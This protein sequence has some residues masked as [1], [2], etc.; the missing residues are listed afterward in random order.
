MNAGGLPC[1]LA[2]RA[3]PACQHAVG[4]APSPHSPPRSRALTTTPSSAL[5]AV[6]TSA[7]ARI[8]RNHHHSPAAYHRAFA[9]AHHR[10]LALTITAPSAA[11]L[12]THHHRP[13]YWPPA[14]RLPLATSPTVPSSAT[15]TWCWYHPRRRVS[16][17]TTATTLPPPRAHC[18][19]T[20][21]HPASVMT[22]STTSSPWDRDKVPVLP[23]ANP[24]PPSPNSNMSPILQQGS[25]GTRYSLKS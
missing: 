12:L 13:Q 17:S 5:A 1:A 10:A 9:R 4:A 24:F 19:T 21:D 7:F 2:T 23:V 3:S 18:R 25:A 15:R 6:P 8:T 11:L 20:R 14:M 16:R 22:V